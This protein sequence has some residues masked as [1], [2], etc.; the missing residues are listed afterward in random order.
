[1]SSGGHCRSWRQMLCRIDAAVVLQLGAMQTSEATMQ[2]YLCGD[3]DVAILRAEVRVTVVCK[4][5]RHCRNWKQPQC[6]I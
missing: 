2:D 1:M 3:A 6:R 5:R 4:L